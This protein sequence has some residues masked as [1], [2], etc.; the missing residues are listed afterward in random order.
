MQRRHGANGCKMH[1]PRLPQLETSHDEWVKMHVT[2]GLITTMVY[3][4]FMTCIEA[5]SSHVYA[6]GLVGRTLEQAGMDAFV[7]WVI[8]STMKESPP[9]AVHNCLIVMTH[10][11]F[12]CECIIQ[13]WDFIMASIAINCVGPGPYDSPYIV[14]CIAECGRCLQRGTFDPLQS[15]R[16][17]DYGCVV[18]RLSELLHTLPVEVVRKVLLSL[19][20]EQ[21]EYICGGND[22]DMVNFYTVAA[23]TSSM[24]SRQY[25]PAQTVVSTVVRLAENALLRRQTW[26][27]GIKESYAFHDMVET[28]FCVF[29]RM[30]L[31]RELALE[32]CTKI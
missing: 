30:D 15:A 11:D 2:D 4:D 29:D 7:S 3:N 10:R 28:L 24:I 17:N 1:W 8:D 21:L 5:I 13:Y 6:A 12:G 22:V 9:S 26:T 27:D 20:R 19:G 14:R 16:S 18:L 23:G 31:P 25:Y 32:V